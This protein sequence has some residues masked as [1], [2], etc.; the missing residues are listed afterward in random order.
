MG[1]IAITIDGTLYPEASILDSERTSKGEYAEAVLALARAW[2]QGETHFVLHT[3]GSTGTPQPVLL[4]RKQMIASANAT[5]CYLPIP[6]H[7]AFGVCVDVRFIG[8]MMQVIRALHAKRPLFVVSPSREALT[9][10]PKGRKL[11]LVSVVPLQLHHLLSSN[12]SHCLS[13]CV[14]TLVG[15]GMIPFQVEKQ[16]KA[17]PYSIYHSYGMT[18]TASH[19]ALRNLTQGEEGFRALPSVYLRRDAEGVLEVKGPMT[20]NKWVSTGDEVRIK[21]RNAFVWVGR[22]D[23]VVNTGGIKVNL[24]ALNRQLGV[25]FEDIGEV[26][27]YFTY[28]VPDEALGTKIVLVLEGAKGAMSDADLLTKLKAHCAPYHAPRVLYTT[29]QFVR[30]T[31]GKTNTHA[32]AQAVLGISRQDP[33]TKPPK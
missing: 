14:I 21:K 1:R 19:V 29:S 13:S 27:D 10:L 25:F 7:M 33:Y 12:Q 30:T 2:L 4:T 26:R 32:T 18:E 8:G 6:A 31:S 15:G 20:H 17:L 24:D 16:L 22:R 11:G 28:G 3:S 5:L 9:Q 23:A